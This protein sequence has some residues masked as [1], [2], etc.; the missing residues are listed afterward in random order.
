[1]RTPDSVS[2]LLAVVLALGTLASAQAGEPSAGVRVVNVT[3]DS[4]P[5]WRPSAEQ[6][7]RAEAAV[8]AF[9]ADL[10]NG[11]AT[12]AYGRLDERNRGEAFDDFRKRIMTFRGVAGAVRERRLVAFTWT[13]DSPRTPVPGIYVATDVVSHFERVE[14]HCGYVVL[15]ESPSGDYRVM[16]QE[17]AFIDDATATRIARQKTGPSLDALWEEL[18]ANCPNYPRVKPPLPEAP[19]STIGYASAAE[20]LAA[21]RVKPGVEISTQKG[22]TVATDSP[23][24]TIWSFTPAAHPAH[25]A[26]VKRS[27][28]QQGDQVSLEMKVLCQAGKAACDDLVRDFTALNE[29]TFGTKA[30]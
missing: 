26:A 23:A 6:E 22:W 17:D 25:P 28:V 9:L 11:R 13:K 12:E 27:V 4:Q 1:M 10:D 24:R 20:A 14:R 18:S 29:A 7:H 3:S 8:R 30:R 15:R 21:L 19:N 16:R 5:G 2:R